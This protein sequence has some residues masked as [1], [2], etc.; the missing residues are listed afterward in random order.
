L[1]KINDLLDLL[2]RIVLFSKIDLRYKDHHIKV[3]VKDGKDN[4][5]R[6]GMVSVCIGDS[7]SIRDKIFQ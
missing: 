1:A 5:S 6:L 4:F 7:I 2:H 3:K